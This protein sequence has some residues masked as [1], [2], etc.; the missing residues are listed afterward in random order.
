M[1]K[2]TWISLFLFFVYS[3]AWALSDIEISGELD[4]AASVWNLPTG[5][6]GNSAFGIPSLYLNMDVPLK[7]DNLL[8]L[9]V[10]G[11]ESVSFYT[12]RFDLRVQKVYLDVVSLFEGMQ[13]LRLGLIPQPWQEAQY[14]VW[15]YYFLGLDAF[16]IT[17]KWRYQS[18]TDLGASFMSEL[19]WNLGEWAFSLTNGEGPEIVEA[20]PHK[21]GALFA[22][23]TLWQPWVLSLNYVRG[24]YDK[25]GEDVGLKERAQ[26][27][28]TYQEDD[29]LLVGLEAFISQDPADALRDLKMAEGVDVTELSGEAVRGQGA[30]LFTV[31]STGPKADVMLRYDYLKP[32]SDKEGKDLQTGIVALGYQV[33]EDIKAA[34]A[35]DYTSYG[36]EY[37]SGLRDRSKLEFATQVLF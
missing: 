16:V 12:E 24:N 36:S 2:N 29:Q 9:T 35:V 20:G 3:S 31:V 37:A 18:Y 5:S 25:Y 22:R 11:S 7:D 30:S 27:M 4:V 1:K 14:E 21:E 28:L 33:T 15:P 8:V 10:E 13:G 17:D 34:V 23:L 6:R 26:V 19:P 32:V